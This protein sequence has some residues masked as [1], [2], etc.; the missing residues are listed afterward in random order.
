MAAGDQNKVQ[1]IYDANLLEGSTEQPQL[2]TYAFNCLP[3]ETTTGQ[4][5]AVCMISPTSVR[6]WPTPDATY[7]FQWR[8]YL[9]PAVF[10]VNSNSYQCPDSFENVILQGNIWKMFQL[11]DDDRANEQYKIFLNE[12]SQL[13]NTEN[14]TNG[15]MR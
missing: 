3:K 9:Q 12:L 5:M 14:R 13:R 6:L 2:D 8:Y 7:T 1:V 10:T 15:R 4:P 11:L